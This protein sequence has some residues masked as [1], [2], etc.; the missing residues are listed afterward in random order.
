[1]GI[2]SWRSEYKIG[3]QQVDSQHQHLLDLTNK[4]FETSSHKEV[5]KNIEILHAYTILHYKEEALMKGC[6]YPN[7]LPH[8]K[9]HDLLLKQMNDFIEQLKDG[10]KEVEEIKPFIGMWL[11]DHVFGADAKFGEFYAHHR[12]MCKN[13]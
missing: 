8:K 4:L 7:Y 2:I 9:D 3:N 6:N 1:M 5:L 13:D 10:R 12:M 11:L